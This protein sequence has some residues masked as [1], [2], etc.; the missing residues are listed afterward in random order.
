MGVATV[1]ALPCGAALAFAPTTLFSL[2]CM[3]G[4]LTAR[5]IAN[6]LIPTMLQDLV[7]AT[8]RARGF[9]D[10]SVLIAAFFAAGPL[11]SGGVSQFV[12]RDDLLSAISLAAAPMLV[13]TLV[14]TAPWCLC[15]ERGAA[16]T[17]SAAS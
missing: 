12:L 7:P 2:W 1:L 5:C 8:L 3:G 9:A 15:G 13:L 17:A 11:L 4:F 6:A 10:Y 16:G 14:C